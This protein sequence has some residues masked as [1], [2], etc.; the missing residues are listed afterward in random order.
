M[1]FIPRTLPPDPDIAANSK[2]RF[3]LRNVFGQTLRA[4]YRRWLR[5]LNALLPVV[6]KT[7][8]LLKVEMSLS[9]R[10]QDESIYCRERSF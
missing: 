10:I 1:E 6:G 4:L 7:T 9:K 5:A 2:S 8:L 3:S